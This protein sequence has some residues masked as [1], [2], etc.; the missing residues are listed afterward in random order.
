MGRLMQILLVV[1]VV[2]LLY[3]L[4]TGLGLTRFLKKP[5][6]TAKS[7]MIEDFE[8]IPYFPDDKDLGWTTN[9]YVQVEAATE[10]QTHGKRSAKAVFLTEGLL[11]PTPTPDMK[12]IPQMILDQNSIKKLK[13][14]L[15]EWQD[16][17][18][19]KMD[20]YN[21]QAGPVTYDLQ[22]S[23]SHSFVYEKTDSL[24]AKGFTNLEI[25]LDEMLKDRLDLSNIWAIRVGV[26]MTGATVPV[27]LY[28]DN[29]HVEG[30]RAA[31]A[32]KQQATPVKTKP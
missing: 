11:Y 28:L 6:I 27:T 19:L 4:A 1:V 15:G 3:L 24:K 31:T 14:P 32:Q 7:M 29:I 9:G 30:D 25:P 12:W 10:N 21:P 16:Y 26:D 20:I 13:Y 2:G 8:K 17:G 5:K 18:S 23:D 22:V